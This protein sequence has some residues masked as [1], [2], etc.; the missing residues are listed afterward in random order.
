MEMQKKAIHSIGLSGLF[1]AIKRP[2]DKPQINGR[3][4]KALRQ[5]QQQSKIYNIRLKSMG[6]EDPLLF[7]ESITKALMLLP[8]NLRQ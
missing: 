2:F 3:D 8:Y 7:S 4:P 5:F 6:Y 1:T